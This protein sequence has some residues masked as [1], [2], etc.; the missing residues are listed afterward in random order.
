M[1]SLVL[2]GLTSVAQGLLPDSLGGLSYS[3]LFWGAVGLVASPVVGWSTAAAFA[4]KPLLSAVSSSLIAG[5]LV[6]V[7]VAVR[8]H[9]SGRYVAMLRGLTL[10]WI[11]LGTAGYSVLNGVK[12][13]G[14][15]APMCGGGT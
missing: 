1:G 5:V 6:L 13:G 10:I 4:R 8:Q 14:Q 11:A 3:P 12:G 9:H 7:I 15:G 2:G